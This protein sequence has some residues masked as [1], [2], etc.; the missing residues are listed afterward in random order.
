M[1]AM[2]YPPAASMPFNQASLVQSYPAMV[3]PPSSNFFVLPTT[4]TM[5]Y[6][7]RFIGTPALY[8]IPTVVSPAQLPGDDVVMTF[9]QSGELA[10][11]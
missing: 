8:S 3:S 9:G 7:E 6:S 11:T 4:T 2:Y 1:A 10:S 5:P